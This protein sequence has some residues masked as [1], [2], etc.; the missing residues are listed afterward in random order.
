MHQKQFVHNKFEADA[1][2]KEA[3]YNGLED[4]LNGVEWFTHEGKFIYKTM[5]DPMKSSSEKM[6]LLDLQGRRIAVMNDNGIIKV[7]EK[8]LVSKKS[9]ASNRL[10]EIDKKVQDVYG[11]NYPEIIRK[12]SVKRSNDT[13]ENAQS[14]KEALEVE[15]SEASKYLRGISGDNKG[16]LTPDSVKVLPE[17]KE[18]KRRFEQASRALRDFNGS[19]VKKYKK[20]L[21]EERT[22][23]NDMRST[24]RNPS[25]DNDFNNYSKMPLEELI[26]EEKA[27]LYMLKNSSSELLVKQTR[28]DLRLIR[29]A[30]SDNFDYNWLSKDYKAKRNPMKKSDVDEIL[31]RDV[32][33]TISS[34]S[35]FYKDY[36]MPLYQTSEKYHMKGQYDSKRFINALQ[37]RIASYALNGPIHFAYSR[38]FNSVIAKADRE[39]VAKEFED[40]FLNELEIGN[41]FLGSK[42]KR[43]PVKRKSKK[44]LREL[45]QTNSGYNPERAEDHGDIVQEFDEAFV[46]DS[47]GYT[48]SW[49]MT[50][51]EDEID[52][53]EQFPR[54]FG[55]VYKKKFYVQE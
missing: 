44:S 9:F 3:I 8:D 27:G 25:K 52:F 1:L 40:Y 16:G 51:S 7:K 43:N 39:A 28:N 30:M 15:V 49:L 45:R 37:S 42:V 21:T 18:A 47:E 4:D 19:F 33:L 41:S 31:V 38:K 55:L 29:K 17:W 48:T 53:I 12:N 50:D 14:V 46:L 22:K 32:Y 24:K 36:L 26:Q 5:I 6:S 54:T 34:E 35:D 10:A 13:F 2:V 20:E 23:R 11:D